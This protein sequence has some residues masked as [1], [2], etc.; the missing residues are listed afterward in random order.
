LNYQGEASRRKV[1][2]TEN[3]FKECGEMNNKELPFGI[4][5]ACADELHRS[6]MNTR[7]LFLANLLAMLVLVQAAVALP[8][9]MA[10][11]DPSKQIR[12]S[13]PAGAE[14]KRQ[15][16]VHFIWANGLPRNTLSAVTRNIAAA[17]FD[18]YLPGIE[19][20]LVAAVDKLDADI[21]PYDFHSISYLL[22]P[23]KTNANNGRLVI[24]HSGHRRALTDWAGGDDVI[25]R[26]LAEGFTVL[27]MDMPVTGFN[28]GHTI[29][30]PNGA[31]VVT[32]A[33]Q[34]SDAHREMFQKLIPALPDGTIFRF[35]L[36]PIVQGINYFLQAHPGAE[37][38]MVG[39]SGGG[40]TATLAPAVDI[41][42]KQSFPVAGSYPL[43]CRTKP[44]PTF[45]HDIEQYY[46][47]LYREIDSD[48]D[49]IADTAAG[50]ASWL[51]IY[52]LGG[53][54][55]GRRQVQILNFNDTCCFFGDAFKTYSNFVPGVVQKLGQ[56]EW[57]F[58]S[59]TTHA[60]HW[61][62]KEVINTVILPCVVGSAD[63]SQAPGAKNTKQPIEACGSHVSIGLASAEGGFQSGGFAQA[64]EAALDIANAPAPLFRDPVF[65]GAADP[66]VLWD[67]KEKAWYIFY[68]QRRANQKLP[69]VSWY[70]DTKIGIAKSTDQGRS[71]SYVG[72]AQGMSRGL[73]AESFWAPHVFEDNGTFHMFVTFV[74]KIAIKEFSGKGQILHYTGRDPVHWKFSDT[75]DVG[76]DDVIDPGLVKLRD[77]RWLMV[78]REDR[79]QPRT[80]MVTSLDLQRWTRLKDVI[81]DRPHEAPVVLYWRSKF[82]LFVDEWRGI[83][84][85]QSD[86]G[87]RY[88]RNSLILDRPGKRADD[89]YLGSHPGVALAGD[90][91]FVFYHCHTDRA[92]A[93]EASGQSRDSLAYKRSSLQVAELELRDGIIVCDRD[94]Y[95]RK[96]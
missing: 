7:F 6:S 61:I 20:N 1:G 24:Y 83:G 76:W 60:R 72:T 89:H 57:A 8:P 88:A 25:N 81:G 53:L 68:T 2:A 95:W 70:Y 80:A 46:D 26:V 45:S 87:I 91:A 34:G 16:L 14:A 31:G 73:E 37:V 39:I 42:I 3:R 32:I 82:W 62:S 36:E 47:P 38:A 27:V 13:T 77:G 86:D 64:P 66:S 52:A 4:I 29:V 11:Y 44:F 94:K 59:D 9:Q 69:G 67:A 93:G 17:M 23:L 22:H 55:P 19:R 54:G 96:K 43:Y 5:Q 10:G 49:G 40:W 90:R 85:Y 75:A 35:F 51:E 56:G 65:D 18:Q 92:A 33:K 71:W 30:L 50:V 12:F 41:R 21:T 58:H 79:P 15:E 78:F 74:P 63:A 28:T 84:V 48:G